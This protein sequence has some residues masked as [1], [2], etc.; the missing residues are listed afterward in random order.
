[1]SQKEKNKYCILRHIYGTWKNDTDELI[2]RAGRDSDI[3]NRL[4]DTEWKKRV[5]PTERVAF[6]IYRQPCIK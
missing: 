4:V 5:G 1:M 2:C 6:D 3:E